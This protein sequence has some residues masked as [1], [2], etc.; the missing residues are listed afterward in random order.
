MPKLVVNGAKLRCDQ[1][2][3]PSSFSVPPAKGSAVDD[4][5]VSTVMDSVPMVNIAPFGM[6]KTQANPQVA[7]ATTAASGTLTPM[8]CLPVV[9]APWSP[10]S[11][12]VTLGEVKALTDDSTCSCTWKGTITITDAGSGVETD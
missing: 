9:T 6:C 2:T 5:P 4:Q 3:S 8:P 11:S 7:T 12:L 1:G 10:G